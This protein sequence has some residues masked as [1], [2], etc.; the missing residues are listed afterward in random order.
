M[1]EKIYRLKEFKK[2][3]SFQIPLRGLTLE[4]FVKEYNE[5]KSVGQRRVK[6]VPGANSIF[7][8]DLKGDYRAVP[9]IWFENGEKRVPESNMLLNQILEKHPWYGVY[10]EVWSEEAEVNKKLT[11]HK[12]R[13]EVLAVINETSDDQR[14]AIALAVFGVNAIQWTDSKAELELREYAKLKPFELKKVLE[15]KDYQSKYLAALAF[16]KDIVKDNIGSTAVIWNDTTQGEI[17]SLARGENGLVKFG[18][19]LSQNTE[20]SLLVL[21]SLNQKIDSL[22]ISNQKESIESSK[23]E[24]ENAELR[25]ELAKLQKQSKVSNDTQEQTEIEELREQYLEKTGKKVPNAFSNKVDWIKE[26]LKES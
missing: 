4:K 13:D 14:K 20:E 7:E 12:K 17:L 9:S 3:K 18:D 15:S 5:L 22:V 21:N 6:Y 25:A 24:K 8:E 23:L 11:E 26:K 2:A 19:F 10:Y 16:N 1:G